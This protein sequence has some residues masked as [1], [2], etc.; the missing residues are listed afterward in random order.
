MTNLLLFEIVCI[1][2]NGEV[3]ESSNAICILKSTDDRP[4][5]VIIICTL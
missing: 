5:S 2:V 4:V 3:F 1:K